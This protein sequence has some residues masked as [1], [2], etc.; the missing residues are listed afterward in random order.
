[1][2][3]TLAPA[4]IKKFAVSILSVL[5]RGVSPLLLTNHIISYTFV[6][7]TRAPASINSFV[8]VGAGPFWRG[9]QSLLII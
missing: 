3:F 1:M 9:V 2:A 8:I 7:F 5:W 6:E 4:S